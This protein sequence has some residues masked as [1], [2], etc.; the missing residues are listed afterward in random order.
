MSNERQLEIQS[1]LSKHIATATGLDTT[2]IDID[3]HITSYGLDS[4]AMLDLACDL[5]DWLEQDVEHT[6]LYDHPTIETLAKHL[7]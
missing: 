3:K 4:S 1:W 7:A 5:E 6:I 2:Q